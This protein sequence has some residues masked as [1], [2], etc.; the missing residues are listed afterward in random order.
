MI[1]RPHPI[2][3]WGGVECTINRVGENFHEQL[4]RS[5]HLDRLSDIDRFAELG[6]R[7][8]RVPVIWELTAPELEQSPC[9]DRVDPMLQRVRSHGIRP[10][11]GLLHHGSGPRYTNLLDPAFVQHLTTYARS[12]AQAY[13]WIEDYTPVNEP[14]TTARFSGLY[15]HW[16]PHASDTASFMRALVNECRGTSS[17]MQAIREVQP[18]ARLVQTEDIATIRST[19]LLAY[20][21][22]YEN[23]RRFLTFDLLCGR[24]DKGHFMYGHLRY[25]GISE[26]ELDWFLE[27]PCPPDVLGVNYYFTSDRYL[28]ESLES[29]PAWSHG[30]NGR[31]RYADIDSGR[32]QGLGL[33]GH[34]QMLQTVWDRYHLPVAITEVHA[35]CTRE[36]QMRWLAEAW[37][38]AHE[39]RDNG[40]DVRAVT[41]WAL[42][43]SYDW[44]SLVR[45][46]AG[47]YETGVFDLRAPEPRPT[48]LAAMIRSLANTGSYD[49]PVLAGEGWWR[50]ASGVR[51]NRLTPA[52]PLLIT[53]GRGALAQ[54]FA[55]H[56]ELR[57]LE[58]RLLSKEELDIADPES[59]RAAL[60]SLAPWAVVNAAG[61]PMTGAT[62]QHAEHCRRV[63]TDGP[64]VL[65][66]ACERHGTRLL[67]FSSDHVFDGARRTPYVESD[68]VGP[69]SIYGASQAE[70]ERRI[71]EMDADA[72]IVRTS[73]MFGATN[74][75][76][77]LIGRALTELSNGRKVE[78]PFTTIVSPTYVPDLVDVCLDLLIDGAAQLW[79]LANVGA[80]SADAFLRQ[81]L[82]ACKLPG[83]LVQVQPGSQEPALPL[84]TYSVLGSERGMYMPPLEDA[85][86]RYLVSAPAA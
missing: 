34:R 80:V 1:D 23:E 25:H 66:E 17:A 9:F 27:H 71:L 76:G 16:Y 19:P 51:A 4:K 3:L 5:C 29:H 64:V 53:G 63:N 21:A 7:A 50:R 61:V 39:A 33:V 77:S 48:A 49:H 56:C 57:G 18:K 35:G 83:E 37:R 38:G 32:V 30:G 86:A 46:E 82:S 52:R 54:A 20:Q 40:A 28:D 10:I 73:S 42:L 2:E 36:E 31:H 43:G 70:A 69:L 6:L 13:P 26:G 47:V 79:H 55:R 14:L 24:V 78:L 60:D 72:L 45:V 62:E 84:P 22:E 58:H 67:T 81:L 75:R 8:L 12:V 11:A 85:I 44:N 41:P 15:G 68:C 74:G 65:A 59:V